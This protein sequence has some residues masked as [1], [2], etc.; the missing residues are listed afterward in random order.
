MVALAALLLSLT[1]T[2]SLSP[3]DFFPDKAGLV[4][5]YKDSEMSEPM[6][7]RV[8][9][10]AK[11]GGLDLIPIETS[12]GGRPSNNL[13]YYRVDED[14]VY[15][16][17]MDPKGRPLEDQQPLF[18]WGKGNGKWNFSGFTQ[19]ATVLEPLN[20]TGETRPGGIRDVLGNKVET[21]VVKL[22]AVISMVANEL[23]THQELVL[24]K[25]IGI[26][27]EQDTSIFGK[28][29][30]RRKLTLVTLKNPEE[31]KD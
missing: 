2:P 18:L 20:L 28:K 25:G 11:K 27:E 10:T 1:Q 12:L 8:L 21:I 3:A 16:V 6:I 19:V 24:A 31:H 26:I 4:L 30:L 14:G 9:P 23:R 13:I 5:T 7:R 22:D 15:M 29:K 17:W